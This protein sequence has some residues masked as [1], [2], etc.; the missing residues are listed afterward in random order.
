MRVALCTQRWIDASLSKAHWCQ[1][2]QMSSLWSLLLPFRSFG[3]A[4]ETSRLIWLPRRSIHHPFHQWKQ[5]KNHPI[6]TSSA[7]STLEFI[8]LLSAAINQVLVFYAHKNIDLTSI[9]HTQ[10]NPLYLFLF[11]HIHITHSQIKNFHRKW[12][13]LVTWKVRR[14]HGYE[15]KQKLIRFNY[16]NLLLR[17]D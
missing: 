14:K 4:H 1:A 16:Y 12:E 9:L 6:I 3:I 10:R 13:I 5:S 7:D 8:D 17:L 2:I 15:I 11:S